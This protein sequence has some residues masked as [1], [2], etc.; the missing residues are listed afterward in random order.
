M[1]IARQRDYPHLRITGL[2]SD[3]GQVVSGAGC[4]ANVNRSRHL[5]IYNN[6]VVTSQST[7]RTFYNKIVLTMVAFRCYDPSNARGGFHEWYDDLSP[8]CRSAVDAILELG[9]RDRTLEQS[10][11]FKALRGKCL[12]LSEVLVDFAMNR[13]T[14]HIRILGFGRPDDFVLLLGFRKR[15]GPDYGPA[16]HAAHNR[17]KGVEHDRRRARPCRFP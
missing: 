10:G 3:P 4:R 8:E 9:A 11:L 14:I 12:G 5:Q 6:F 16:C 13:K 7:T 15:G 2:G 17:K 1:E